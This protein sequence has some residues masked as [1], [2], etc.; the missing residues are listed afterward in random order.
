M[1]YDQVSM[2]S[3]RFRRLQESHGR[4]NRISVSAIAAL[5]FIGGIFYVS[6]Q[7]DVLVYVV[8]ALLSALVGVLI[9][10]IVYL[11]VDLAD[12]QRS[13]LARRT[14]FWFRLCRILGL[15][16]DAIE[17]VVGVKMVARLAQGYKVPRS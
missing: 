17:A 14:S 16:N 5:G 3:S 12:R 4:V 9:S 6:K 1:L 7:A 13:P 8:P 2:G 15:P 10:H 11:A